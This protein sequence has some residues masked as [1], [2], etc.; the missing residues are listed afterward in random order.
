LEITEGQFPKG[1]AYLE[2]KQPQL[3]T[4]ISNL[5]QQNEPVIISYSENYRPPPSQNRNRPANKPPSQLIN[6]PM[7]SKSTLSGEKEQ[8]DWYK[9]MY[10][11]LHVERKPVRNAKCTYPAGRIKQGIQ[12]R[13]N[14]KKFLGQASP[15]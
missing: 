1:A 6:I 5:S 10:E 9:R 8:R 3:D 14:S 13:P 2:Q 12:Y 15:L 4:R 11:S 7:T